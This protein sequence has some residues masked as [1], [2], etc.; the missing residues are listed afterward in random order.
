M[1]SVSSGK[2][3]GVRL[4]A[5]SSTLKLSSLYWSTSIFLKVVLEVFF[6]IATDQLYAEIEKQIPINRRSSLFVQY[7]ISIYLIGMISF[8]YDQNGFQR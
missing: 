3:D 6:A 4:S 2:L 1:I 8:E 7:Y 5:V